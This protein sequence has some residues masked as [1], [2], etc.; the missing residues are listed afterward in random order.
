MDTELDALKLAVKTL[1]GHSA[2][3]K[4]IGISQQAVTR[5]MRHGGRVPAEWCLPLEEAT[6]GKITRHDLRPDLYPDPPDATSKQR[7]SL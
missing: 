6:N 3:A 1:G 7:F 5:K 4:A 2:T